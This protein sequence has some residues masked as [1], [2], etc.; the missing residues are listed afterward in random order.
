MRSGELCAAPDSR[1]FLQRTRLCV[2]ANVPRVFFT[3]MHTSPPLDAEREACR[4]APKRSAFSG[5]EITVCQLLHTRRDNDAA[6]V[7]L[8]HDRLP[9][10]GVQHR[11]DDDANSEDMPFDFT[12]EN[13]KIVKRIL[14]KYPK[15]YKQ[16]RRNVTTHIYSFLRTFASR[17]LKP[18]PPSAQRFRSTSFAVWYY[19]ALGPRATA[20]PQF[21]PAG[22]D[23]Q[24]RGRL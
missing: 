22:C 15:N 4:R 20:M 7:S 3:R 10:S 18:V 17:H 11:S 12:E 5:K 8:S 9:S 2:L 24:S 6:I 23:V 13:Y 16:V 21:S 1:Q 14:A 19:P